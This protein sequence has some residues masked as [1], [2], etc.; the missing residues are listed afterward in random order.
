MA[1]IREKNGRYE[2]R[3]WLHGRTTS[4]SFKDIKAAK[5]WALG[6]ETG[7]IDVTKKIEASQIGQHEHTLVEA[8]RRYHAETAAHKKGARQEGERIRMLAG[9]EWANKPLSKVTPEDLKAYRSARLAQ[10]RS[11]ST[12]RLMLCTVSAVYAHAKEEWGYRGEN[13]MNS[14]KL[15]K[16]PAARHRR[17]SPEEETLLLNALKDCRNP[18]VLRAAVL[19]LETG[20]RRSELLS[21]RWCEVDQI[22]RLAFLPDTKN[23]QVRWVPLT[24]RALSILPEVTNPQDRILPITSSLLTQAF[25]HAL[26]ASRNTKSSVARPSPRGPQSMGASPQW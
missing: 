3:V 25:G 11:T 24:E 1:S 17:L 15:P 16:P 12:V 13:P 4:K 23:G 8:A 9:Y 7:L 5:K 21:L 2:V 26:K 20:M 10:G 18:M 22:R 19:A 14:V 6:V